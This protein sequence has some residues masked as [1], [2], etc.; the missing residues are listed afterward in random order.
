MARRIGLKMNEDNTGAPP[1][2]DLL[3]DS[4]PTPSTS[5]TVMRTTYR[6][7]LIEA[8]GT[9]IFLSMKKN[10]VMD[11]NSSEKLDSQIIQWLETENEKAE[12]YPILVRGMKVSAF[13]VRRDLRL[14]KMIDFVKHDDIM[15]H[16]G[17]TEDLLVSEGVGVLGMGLRS[18]LLSWRTIEKN[19]RLI[20]RFIDELEKKNKDD[21]AD[22]ITLSGIAPNEE[23]R[24][25]MFKTQIGY[26]ANKKR[27]HLT[28]FILPYFKYVYTNTKQTPDLTTLGK[29]KFKCLDLDRLAIEASLI[30]RYTEIVEKGK[31][32]EYRAHG[33]FIVHRDD[34]TERKVL[35]YVNCSKNGTKV[36]HHGVKYDDVLRNIIREKELD[37]KYPTALTRN[38][39]KA[40]IEDFIKEE[41]DGVSTR[42]GMHPKVKK[43]N[44]PICRDIIFDLDSNEKQEAELIL[45]DS[46]YNDNRLIL[47][48][49]AENK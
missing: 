36:I 24:V 13:T 21:L 17:L 22:L 38:D 29:D 43:Y 41:S 25:E 49:P 20:D 33:F 15:N 2:E 32:P 3:G 40:N 23:N 4:E 47:T 11:P 31:A 48:K 26:G 12:L 44:S 9:P 42:M 16:Y 28:N 7:G 39:F 34:K 5:S 19:P 46:G 10:L 45:A 35:Q 30:S 14:D 8:S 6:D 37:E 18:K 27:I 1:E